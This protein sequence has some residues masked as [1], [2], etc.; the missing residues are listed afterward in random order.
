MPAAGCSF[1]GSKAHGMCQGYSHT[2]LRAPSSGRAV[3]TQF[4]TTV[5]GDWRARAGG[6]TGVKFHN[7]GRRP[8]TLEKS[9]IVR[10]AIAAR[11]MFKLSGKGKDSMQAA[12]ASGSGS[13][14]P[15]VAVSE[16][17]KKKAQAAKSF[18]ENMYKNQHENVRERLNRRSKLQKELDKEGVSAEEKQRMLEEH[19]KMESDFT[20]LQRQ[21]LMQ[22]DF[23][24][25]T[26]IGRGAFGEV[27]NCNTAGFLECLCCSAYICIGTNG[28]VKGHA[29]IEPCMRWSV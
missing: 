25:L 14:V 22:D 4:P 27:R 1:H 15:A 12:E 23:D 10:A 26:I 13:D 3:G 28:V 6:T 8:I 21:R 17:A 2:P 7:L 19:A 16:E 9:A 18:I 20:R 5:Q 11:S 29:C 24:L